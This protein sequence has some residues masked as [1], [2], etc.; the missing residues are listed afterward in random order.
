MNLS[1]LAFLFLVLIPYAKPSDIDFDLEC[2]DGDNT[3][4]FRHGK[5]EKLMAEA[6]EFMS[7]MPENMAKR[8]K[9]I[10]EE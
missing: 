5:H 9:V 10:I 4:I 8:W 2:A 1:V 6:E 7:L 3:F